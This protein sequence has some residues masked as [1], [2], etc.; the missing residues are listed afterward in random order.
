[1]IEKTGESLRERAFIE[2]NVPRSGRSMLRPYDK[3]NDGKMAKA[4]YI[5]GRAGR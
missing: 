5:T 3:N 1:M 2:K 4:S